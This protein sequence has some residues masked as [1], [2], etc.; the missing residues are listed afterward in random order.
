MQNL[1]LTQESMNAKYLGLPIYM[2]R[3]KSSLF[4]YL[5]ERLWKRIQG[6]KEKLLSKAGKETL[7]KAVAQAI[8]AYAMSCFDLTKFL[9]DDMS[10]MICR[11]WWSQQ[12]KENNMHWVS[13]EEVCRRKEE[14]GLRYRDLH[15][16]NLA[17][18]AQQGWRILQNLDSLCAQL[19]NAKYGTNDSLL[20]AKEG[21]GISY[22]WRSKR[23]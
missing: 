18:L 1:D 22:S 5:K 9:C 3:S 19:L 2:G 8:P 23:A 7:I 17:M 21:P 10:K 11:Y 14:G 16:F 6:W 15:L 12:D 4:A 20:Q 13:W